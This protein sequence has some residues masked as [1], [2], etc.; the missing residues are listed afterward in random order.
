MRTPAAS[1]WTLR[2]RRIGGRVLAAL[3]LG[4][5]LALPVSS[6]AAARPNEIVVSAANYAEASPKVLSEMFRKADDVTDGPPPPAAN[7]PVRYYQFLPAE[8]LD[9]DL[10]YADVCKLL[11]PALTAK[12]LRN[13]ADQAKVELILRVTF[14]GRSWR[15]PFVRKDD[16]E[17]KHGLVPKRRG[18]SLSAA[19]AWDE[20]AGGSEAA[21]YQ[22]ERDM[23]EVSPSAEGMADRLI[24]GK[25]T[26]DY[27]LIVVDAFEVA[28][29]KKKGNNTP[30]IWSTFIAVP[31]QKGVKFGDVATNMIAKAAPYFGETAPGKIHFTD[32]D[33][34]VKVGDLKVIEDHA[35]APAAKK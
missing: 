30:R 7:R 14:G 20:R 2:D 23:S 11:L 3:T 18:T 34:N 5:A 26:G 6:H 4:C 27:Y 12:N 15:D 29:L 31:R 9:A 33:T 13:T 8:S 32:R 1:T 17:W 22:L 10:S 24:G 35:L 25:S 28:T 19:Q 21:L 16:L